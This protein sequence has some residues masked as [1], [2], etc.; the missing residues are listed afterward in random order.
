MDIELFNDDVPQYNLV[1][2]FPFSFTVKLSNCRAL[3]NNKLHEHEYNHLDPLIELVSHQ[4]KFY[5]FQILHGRKLIYMNYVA[6]KY[7]CFE[8]RKRL[9][10]NESMCSKFLFIKAL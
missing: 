1:A 5:L 7:K 3:Q 9:I 10:L 6:R 4:P 8:L 2:S